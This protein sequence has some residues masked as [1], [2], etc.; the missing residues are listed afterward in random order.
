MDHLSRS[1]AG[2]RVTRLKTLRERNVTNAERKEGKKKKFT[3]TRAS[4]VTGSVEHDVEGE[5]RDI[6]RNQTPITGSPDSDFKIHR[7]A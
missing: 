3:D 2:G 6:P 5:G 4:M 1:E 7:Q